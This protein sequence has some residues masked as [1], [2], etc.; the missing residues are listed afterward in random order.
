MN[1]E[2]EDLHALDTGLIASDIGMGALQTLMDYY[3]RMLLF[4]YKIIAELTG[5]SIEEVKRELEEQNE[6]TGIFETSVKRLSAT[7]EVLGDL[8]EYL[9]REED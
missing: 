7:K 1:F 4:A 9:E 2:E 3:P 8:L 5:N 6:L